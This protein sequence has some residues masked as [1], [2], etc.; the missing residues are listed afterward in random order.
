MKPPLKRTMGPMWFLARG[1]YFRIM[2]REFTSVFI[3]IYLVFFLIL[4]HKVSAGPL[5]YHAYLEFLWSP[6][7]TIF[8]IVA[9]AF[10]LMH[11]ITWFNLTP[12]AMVI[13]RG[14]DKLPPVAIAGPNYVVWVAVSLFIL[15]IVL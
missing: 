4:L 12:Q 11:T 10:A 5:A 1:A 3:A 13:R 14:E 6:G 8:H 15:W 2:L 9:L 7:M